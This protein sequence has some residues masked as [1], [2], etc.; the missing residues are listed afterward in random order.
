MPPWRPSTYG[1]CALSRA[2]IEA[3]QTRVSAPVA[4]S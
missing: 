1:P 2:S 3:S 4:P